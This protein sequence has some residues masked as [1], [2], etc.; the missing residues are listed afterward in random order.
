MTRAGIANGLDRALSR[1]EGGLLTIAIVAIAVVALLTVSSIAARYGVPVRIPDELEISQQLLML[2][3]ISALGAVTSRQS[4]IAVDI[5]H[6]HLPLRARR[7]CAV[8]ASVAGLCFLLP[9]AIWAFTQFQSSLATGSHYGG[10]LHLPE[11]P[12][13]LAFSIGLFVVC[14][15]L[16]LLTFVPAVPKTHAQET[17]E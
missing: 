5:L 4:H 7:L 6:D 12:G 13:K 8:I 3:I 1:V 16:L 17:A 2:S 11:W 15:R 14:L 9:I 10:V